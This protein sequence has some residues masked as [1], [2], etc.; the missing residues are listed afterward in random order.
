MQGTTVI[1]FNPWKLK[2]CSSCLKKIHPVNSNI[3][4]TKNF[5]KKGPLNATLDNGGVNI[6]PNDHAMGDVIL[7]DG[8]NNFVPGV[9]DARSMTFDNVRIIFIPI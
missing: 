7:H 4:Q 6:F 8:A 1:G 3:Y 2:P 9:I 5:V